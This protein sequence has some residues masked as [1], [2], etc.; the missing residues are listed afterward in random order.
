LSIDSRSLGDRG[1]ADQHI[2]RLRVFG[3]RRY[4]QKKARFGVYTDR[5]SVGLARSR[6]SHILDDLDVRDTVDKDVILILK[7]R[8]ET[9][10]RGL[11]K[12]SSSSVRLSSRTASFGRVTGLGKVVGVGA[13]YGRK[14]VLKPEPFHAPLKF[15]KTPRGGSSSDG[16]EGSVKSLPHQN[17]S[18]CRDGF[19][20][21][22]EGQRIR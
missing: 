5:V 3:G 8:L 14:M 12:V 18:L 19:Q 17:E 10:P 4:G 2:G 1:H 9:V 7:P 16:F 21:G 11:E 13:L 20:H 22:Q 6:V 15:C